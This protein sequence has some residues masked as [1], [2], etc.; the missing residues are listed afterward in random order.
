MPDPPSHHA[1]DLTS[2]GHISPPQDRAPRISEAIF[3]AS[4]GKIPELQTTLEADLAA[5]PNFTHLDF[6]DP[7]TFDDSLKLQ[8][9]HI[10][11]R[12]QR[13]LEEAWRSEWG[14][15]GVP[16]PS[17]EEEWARLFSE[18]VVY[19]GYSGVKWAYNTANLS[20]QGTPQY[21]MCLM[22]RACDADDPAFPISMACQHLSTLCMLSRGYAIQDLCNLTIVQDA[23]SAQSPG[24]PITSNVLT[25][26]DNIKQIRGN[27]CGCGVGNNG[28]L[29]LFTSG[30]AKWIS[31]GATVVKNGTKTNVEDSSYRDFEK[32][33]TKA[34]LSPGSIIGFNPQGPQPDESKD[35]SHVGS[36]LRLRMQP[37]GYSIQGIDTGPL[38]GESGDT[39]TADHNFQ[40]GGAL[41]TLPGYLVGIGVLPQTP[42]TAE[43]LRC[44]RRTRPLGLT[45]LVLFDDAKRVRF[46]SSLMP[47]HHNDCGFP[48]SK[49]VWSLRDLPPGALK[50]LWLVS[51]PLNAGT[52][53][54][55]DPKSRSGA[56]ADSFKA[57]G[58]DFDKTNHL[59]FSMDQHVV[60]NE[61][62]SAVAL[63]RYKAYIHAGKSVTNWVT[64]SG[65]NLDEFPSYLGQLT[66]GTKPK[67][68]ASLFLKRFPAS[69]SCVWRVSGSDEHESAA[70]LLADIEYFGGGAP[71]EPLAVAQVVEEPSDATATQT[72]GS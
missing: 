11:E 54:L 1:Y 15:D 68:T 10:F 3:R 8:L 49:L 60:V 5:N 9:R 61:S 63:F 12:L 21:E 44:L 17:P 30:K 66:T 39:I 25:D 53:A 40:K 43:A 65:S 37:G 56:I 46:I 48:V 42:P 4:A 72:Q 16:D 69:Q 23:T 71:P 19:A 59:A 70:D 32:L 27:L 2:P 7:K 67:V 47:L 38:G 33:I 20:I 14:Y 28:G 45:R 26:L 6:S 22:A 31:A 58:I 41:G 36:V 34:N 51:S 18:Q 62:S 52:R 55:L 57:K 50:G 13:G 24:T 29:P 64:R 35:G